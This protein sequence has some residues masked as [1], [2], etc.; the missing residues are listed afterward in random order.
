MGWLHEFNLKRKVAGV[1]AAHRGQPLTSAAIARQSKAD[2]REVE[3][4]VDVMEK[5]DYVKC[6]RQDGTSAY[7]LDKAQPTV[8]RVL[9]AFQDKEQEAMA[10]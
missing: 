7:L 10:P 1:L 6:V 3:Q 9:H 8:G 5:G 4:L 2:E